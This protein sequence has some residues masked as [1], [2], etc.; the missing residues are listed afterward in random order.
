MI[1]GA[2]RPPQRCTSADLTDAKHIVALDRLEHRSMVRELFPA[3]TERIEY[4]DIGDIGVATPD[5][6]LA[7]IEQRIEALILRLPQR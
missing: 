2:N 1:N 4:W 5:V 6:A 3:W 7:V